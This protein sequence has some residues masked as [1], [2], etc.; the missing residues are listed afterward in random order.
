MNTEPQISVL[1]NFPGDPAVGIRSTYWEIKDVGWLDDYPEQ[2]EEFRTKLQEAFEV[3]TGG[4]HY[5]T[6]SDES[7]YDD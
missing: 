7:R 6:F 5:V 4:G 3:I 2:R 1:I